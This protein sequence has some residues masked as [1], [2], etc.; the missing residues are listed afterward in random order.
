MREGGKLRGSREGN[1][2]P[3]MIIFMAVLLHYAAS[4]RDVVKWKPW[5]RFYSSPPAPFLPRKKKMWQDD[6]NTS[7]RRSSFL[8]Q[9]VLNWTLRKSNGKET[10]SKYSNKLFLSEIVSP[11]GEMHSEVSKEKNRLH[12]VRAPAANWSRGLGQQ[13]DS[14]VH[15]WA[16]LQGCKLCCRVVWN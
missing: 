6:R 5:V 12:I 16:S 15:H 7:A 9:S 13:F 14:F 4:R 3:L 11:S 2:L 10:F 8:K 1:N